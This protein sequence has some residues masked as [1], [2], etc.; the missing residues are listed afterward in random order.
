MASKIVNMDLDRKQILTLVGIAAVI[1][2][3]V[4]VPPLLQHLYGINA[5][6]TAFVIIVIYAALSFYMKRKD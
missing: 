6:H 4:G 5:V 2:G 1:F 3:I